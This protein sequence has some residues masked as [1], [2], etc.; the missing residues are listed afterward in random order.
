[1]GFAD[2]LLKGKEKKYKADPLAKDI[3]AAGKQGLTNMREAGTNLAGIYKQDP[4]GVVN[5]QIAMENRLMRGAA[6]DAINRTR[7][8]VA[9]RG[10]ANSSVGLGTEVNQAR[11]LNDKLALNNAS[12]IGRLRDMSIENGQGLM[13]TGNALFQTKIQ[14]QQNLQ[15]QDIKKRQGGLAGLVG[16]GIGA[17]YGGPQGA[18][19]GMA[20]GNAYAES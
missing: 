12:A 2:S 13:N 16:A 6:D 9:Q 4:S 14:G 18:Q 3:N 5:S 17:Y 7:Q 10:M 8:L 20:M 11:Q 19:A 1:M 15:M